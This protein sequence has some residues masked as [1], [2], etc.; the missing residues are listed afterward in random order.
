M[1]ERRAV[2]AAIQSGATMGLWAASRLGLTGFSALTYALEVATLA[3]EGANDDAIVAKV[4]EDFR[5]H[6]VPVAAHSLRSKFRH[7]KT[8]SA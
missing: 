3:S 5:G 6:G 2:E 4:A 1:T 8:A 7:R